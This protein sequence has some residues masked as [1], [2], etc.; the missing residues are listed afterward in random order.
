MPHSSGEKHGKD[1][2]SD[3]LVLETIKDEM[4]Y[5]NLT[6]YKDV[7]IT[8]VVN[9]WTLTDWVRYRTRISARDD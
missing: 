4:L 8:N 1:Y 6:L 5:T 9:T 7:E 3:E 2:H